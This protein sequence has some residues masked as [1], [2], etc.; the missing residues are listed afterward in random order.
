M[1]KIVSSLKEAVKLSGLKDGMRISFHH[2]LR[3]GDYV[4][5]MVMDEIADL[6]LKDITVNASSVFDTHA[7]LVKH[8]KNKVVTGLE[9][10]Y[11]GAVVGREISS[12]IMDKPVNFR[13]HGGRP[14]DIETGKTPIDVAFIAAPTSDCMGNCSGKYGK[15]ACGSLGYAFADAMYADKVVVITDNLVDYP[16]SDFSIS[17]TYVDYVVCVD[18]IGD[19]SGIVSGT[20]K[21]TKDPVGLMMASYATKVIQHSGLLKDGFSF[22][23]GAGGASLAAAKYLKDLMLKENIKGSFGMGGITGYLVDMLE[24][25][26]FKA[27]MDVQCFDLK[28]VQSLRD[29]PAHREVTASHYASPTTKSAIVDSLDVVILG[30]TQIDT[31]FNVNVHTDSNGYIMGGSGGHSDTAAGAKLTMIVAPLTRAR[32]SIVVDKVLCVST[33]GNTVDV[34]VTQRGIAVNPLRQD[35]KTRLEEA[36][37][38]VVDIHELKNIAE[39]IT[40]VPK[41][42]VMGDKVVGNVIYRDGTIIDTIKNTLK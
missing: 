42:V 18:K 16:L 37:L 4:I 35:L 11:M 7:P 13:S 23:T 29:N 33:P 21:I 28:A 22:Q 2:H 25:G 6:G 38:P 34:L 32:L 10:N 41:N 27:L 26:C 12:G 31:N 19:P 14:S 1:N 39:K 40:G 5:N 30:A 3:N 24:A 15:S 20:T 8:I 36:N 9:V 17:E